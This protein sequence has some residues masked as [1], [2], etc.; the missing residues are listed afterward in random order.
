M[1]GRGSGGAEQGGPLPPQRLFLQRAQ[2]ANRQPRC[3]GEAG[4]LLLPLPQ[5]FTTTTEQGRGGRRQVEGSRQRQTKAPE[6]SAWTGTGTECGERGHHRR[7]AQAWE[8]G[9]RPQMGNW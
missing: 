1:V 7:G 6:R 4:G 3:H 8:E 2:R 9:V 5:L